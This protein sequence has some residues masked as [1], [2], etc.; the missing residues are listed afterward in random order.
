MGAAA[1]LC[2]ILE[3]LLLD[4][5]VALMPALIPRQQK[6]DG[7]KQSQPQVSGLLCISAP[8][9]HTFQ[10]HLWHAKGLVQVYPGTKKLK[11]ISTSPQDMPGTV[12]PPTGQ[13]TAIPSPLQ[14]AS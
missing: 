1:A 11:C 6:E 10:S 3:Q 12:A 4:A 5:G 7:S 2:C 8:H 13:C 14:R 9:S